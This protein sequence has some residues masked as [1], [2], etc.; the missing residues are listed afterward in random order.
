MMM[1]SDKVQGQIFQIQSKELFINK[2]LN[3][4]DRF[5][6]FLFLDGND[7]EDDRAFSTILAAGSKRSFV[8]RTDDPLHELQQF[9]DSSPAWIFG[10]FTYDFFRY[11]FPIDSR[12]LP[13]IE[14]PPVFFFEPEVLIRISDSTIEILC[15]GDSSKIF[16]EINSINALPEKISEQKIHIKNRVSRDDYINTLHSLKAHLQAGD[17]YEINYCQEFF[18]ESV[19]L[20]PYALF[21]SLMKRSPAPFSVLYKNNNKYCI[22]SSPERFIKKKGCEILSQPMK[23]TIT[24]G[25]DAQQDAMNKR[26]L[27][28]SEKDQSENVMIVDLVRNDLSRFCKPGSVV[29][30]EL[31]GVHSFP[32]VHQMISTVRGEMESAQ[33]WTD[34]FRYCFP[35]GSMTGAPKKRVIELSDQYEAAARGLYSGSIGYVTPDADMD[36]NVVI[37]SVFYDAGNNYLNFWAGGGI[38]ISSNPEKEYEESCLKA[39]VIKQILEGA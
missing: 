20:N 5:G 24:R 38:T 29:V 11:N 28:T 13:V 31:F 7:F 12:H 4:V 21:L 37:R 14:F 2:M 39:S 23:G 1:T 34:V 16:E 32:Q 3:W 35:M 6:I 18:S 15:D 10:H 22:S 30:D 8:C 33:N 27:E 9:Y 26:S 25:A 36:F 17:C 19:Q